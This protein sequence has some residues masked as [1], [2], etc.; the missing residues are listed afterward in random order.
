MA[1]ETIDHLVRELLK[2]EEQW[3]TNP[4]TIWGLSTSFPSWDIKTG[5]LH[6]GE[7]T[8]LAARTSQG[9]TALGN[10][11]AF[12]AVERLIDE[13]FETGQNPGQVAIFSPEMTRQR[14][15][16]RYASAASGIPSKKIRTGKA[17]PEERH[18]WRDALD[19]A[20]CFDPF[21]TL[22][23][24]RTIAAADLVNVVESLHAE[25]PIRLL[26]IDYLQLI[27]GQG[28]SAYEQA[29]HS[30]REVKHIAT[31]LNIPVLAMS[32]V[33][34]SDSRTNQNPPTMYELRDSGSLEQDADSVTILHVPESDDVEAVTERTKAFIR[35]EKNRDGETGEFALWFNRPIAKF[36]DIISEPIEPEF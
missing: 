27:P 30:S 18:K 9:K 15:L 22:H 29:T 2:Q 8:L 13:Y 24:G 32:Q 17:T 12:G 25:K 11:V 14:L 6:K 23:A 35:I 28:S 34:R 4:S 26:A 20:T 36:E 33:R 3:H 16:I 21:L 1:K 19:Y 5:G 31:S 10:Q 7:V